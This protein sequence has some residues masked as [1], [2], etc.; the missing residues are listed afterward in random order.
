MTPIT[1]GLFMPIPADKV[2]S[3]DFETY[4]DKD[5][6]LKKLATSE[7][8]RDERFKAQ[9]VGIKVGHDE[10]IW[11]P[12]V[13]VEEAVNC[14]D[15]STH[16]LLAHHAQFDGF[17]LTE[18]FGVHPTFYFCTL[19]M[20]RAL[21]SIG[22]GAGLND[23]AQ[24]YGLGNKLPD[25]LGQ[26]KGVRDWPPEMMEKAGTYCAVD[27]QLCYDLFH[28]ML[29]EFP[30][31][32]LELIDQTCRMF[33]EPVLVVDEERAQLALEEEKRNKKRKIE[34]SLRP[35][36]E[37]SSNVKFA[38]VLR[39]L[40]V[41]PPTKISP[42]TGKETYAFAKSDQGLQEL[43]VH[44]DEAVRAVV[45]ARL[46]VKSTLNETRAERLLNEGKDGRTIPVYL[47]YYGAHT[48][49][50]SAGNKM[51]LQ[52][53]PRGGE[54]RKSLLAPFDHVL[55]VADSAQIEAR[56]LAWIANDHELLRQFAEGE[57]VYKHMA[58][59]IFGVP[60][61]EV[62]KEQRFVGKV[63][64]LGL[65]YKMGWKRFHL[66]VTLGLMGPPM[67]ISLD[68]ARS[69]VNTYRSERLPITKFWDTCDDMLMCMVSDMD[70][71]YGPLHVDGK[72]NRIYFPDGMY[73]EYPELCPDGNGYVYFDY[74][75]AKIFASGGRPNERKTK[76][77]YNGLL[78]ENITQKLARVVVADQLRAV[79]RRQKIVT[80][81]HDELV[82][83]A[84]RLQADEALDFMLEVMRTPPDWCS[85]IPL[86]AEGGYAREYSK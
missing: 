22:M 55:V 12:D 31:S 65:G 48:G 23:L 28:T 76:K 15:W 70:M 73:L 40:G 49:R 50:W 69:T 14:I 56:M 37:L 38:N 2:V 85:D 9:C 30:E 52:N 13:H 35:V 64:I 43:M 10:T 17:I 47:K 45:E 61:D 5:Y 20:G 67:D 74:E 51:N 77:I 19:S 7:Y 39:E 57:D 34:Q 58:S 83:L 8:I 46:A 26:T 33:C 6:T 41:E 11:V 29:P 36:E 16:A 75:N 62:T 60:V 80:M 86:G 68:V 1:A 81:T 84:H 24:F 27:T 63:S 44:D 82:A 66:T 32:E 25:I 3:L 71:D 78:A 18:R 72:R 59:A 21:H 4:F 79:S 53:L 42:T 54:L